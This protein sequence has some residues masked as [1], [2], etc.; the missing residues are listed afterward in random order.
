MVASWGN[1]A[2]HAWAINNAGQVVGSG[3]PSDSNYQA[4]LYSGGKTF[5]LNSLIL[6]NIGWTL[7][8]AVNIDDA[9]RILAVGARDGVSEEHGFL[10][11]P[12]AVP[13]PTSLAVLILGGAAILAR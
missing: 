13:E 8:N 4:F 6:Q 1:A 11:T 10:L 9:G 7:V 3:L 2:S 12:S 5:D